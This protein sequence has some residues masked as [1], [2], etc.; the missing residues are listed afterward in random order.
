MLFLLSVPLSTGETAANLAASG[1]IPIVKVSS[2]VFI[3]G[4]EIIFV[5]S[6]GGILST[7]VAFLYQY[8]LE[9]LL[10]KVL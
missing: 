9:G 1:K 5:D 8:I 6:F 3:R 7:N 4:S 10:Y 2:T